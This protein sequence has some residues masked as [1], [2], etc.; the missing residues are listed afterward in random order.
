MF[1]GVCDQNSPSFIAWDSCS[2]FLD[3][4]MSKLFIAD[5][6]MPNIQ[7]GV[8]LL[9]KVLAYETQVADITSKF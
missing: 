4:V 9:H 5:A 3:A 8:Q 7:D 2:F 1:T 6:E